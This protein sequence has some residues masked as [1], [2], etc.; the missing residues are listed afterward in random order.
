MNSSFCSQKIEILLNV[1]NCKYCYF[2]T[3]RPLG[4]IFLSVNILYYFRVGFLCH[5]FIL[6]FT[7]DGVGVGVVIRNVYSCSYDEVKNKQ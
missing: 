6:V 7:S 1:S 5:I 2:C 3:F 4:S